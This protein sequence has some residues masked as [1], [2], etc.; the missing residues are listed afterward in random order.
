MAKYDWGFD[1]LDRDQ[2]QKDDIEINIV[3]ERTDTYARF[4]LGKNPDYDWGEC[5]ETTM[6][7][8]RLMDA[9]SAL[10]AWGWI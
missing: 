6:P 5:I 4:A 10:S 9:E 3:C 1:L 7:V 2:A 8:D